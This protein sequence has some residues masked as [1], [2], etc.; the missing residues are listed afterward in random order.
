MIDVPLMDHL[1]RARA[2]GTHILFVGDT[3]QLPPVGPGAPLRDMIASGVIG[4]GELTEIKRNS[5]GSL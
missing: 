5:G 3:N 4:V 2:T 1:L